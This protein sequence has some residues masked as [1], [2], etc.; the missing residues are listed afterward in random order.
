M[1]ILGMNLLH[2][3]HVIVFKLI[4]STTRLLTD[5]FHYY[6]FILS[7]AYLLVRHILLFVYDINEYKLNSRISKFVN[8]INIFKSSSS[9]ILSSGMR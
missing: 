2:I 6:T 4:I 8:I 7:V 9:C 3:M 1:C 5:K